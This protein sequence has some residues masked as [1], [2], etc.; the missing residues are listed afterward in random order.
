MFFYILVCTSA[1]RNCLECRERSLPQTPII[2]HPSA[3]IS[4]DASRPSPIQ[5]LIGG[6]QPSAKV[7]FV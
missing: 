2:P 7:D 3:N 4:R 6:V 5:A 1:V